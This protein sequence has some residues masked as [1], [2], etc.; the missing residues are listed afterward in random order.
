MAEDREILREVWQ[1][2]IPVAFSLSPDDVHTMGQPDPYHLMLP[3]LS[4]VTVIFDKVKKHF[5]K[6]VHPDKQDTGM[7]EVGSGNFPDGEIWLEFEGI[8]IKWHI[9]VGVLYDQYSVINNDNYPEPASYSSM[10]PWNLI[11]HFSKFPE[12]DILHC[13][14]RETVEAHFMSCIKEADQIK[15]GG[16]V[17]SAMQKKDHNQLW[18]GLQNDKFDQ[19]WAVNRRLMEVPT[20]ITAIG[21]AGNNREFS[22]APSCFKHIP[23]RFYEGDKSMIQKLIKPTVNAINTRLSPKESSN[24]SPTTLEEN[25]ESKSTIDPEQ[26]QDDQTKAVE[27][28]RLATLRDLLEEM[29]P[30]KTCC[31]VN[32]VTQGI[33]PD[34]DTPLQWM[35]EHLS[36]PDNFL[37]IVIK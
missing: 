2:R 10:L 35:S 36:Y 5:S 20:N 25:S 18:Q 19:F 16:R 8:P 33:K 21:D 30:D 6:F 26:S 3:R 23:I 4:Y 9:P 24:E 14:S 34:L 12:Q 32:A 1:G 11:V 31:E 7:G 22:Q 37:H 13:D 27:L 28:K 17:I 29:L 15:H